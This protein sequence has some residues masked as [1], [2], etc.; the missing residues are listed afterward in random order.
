[1]APCIPKPIPR[2]NRRPWHWVETLFFL[3]TPRPLRRTRRYRRRCRVPG[4]FG[5]AAS[6]HN[7]FQG[8]AY[9]EAAFHQRR[10][11]SMKLRKAAL[12]LALALP[13]AAHAQSS[14]SV[15]L[16]GVVDTAIEYLNNIP[17]FGTMT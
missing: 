5:N 8:F 6:A 10:V 9:I 3:T 13:L 7:K 11:V 14:T 16:Y 12:G 4:S 17:E 2:F 15:T 1:T